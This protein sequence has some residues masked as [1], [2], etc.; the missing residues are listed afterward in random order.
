MA[1]GVPDRIIVTLA[2]RMKGQQHDLVFPKQADKT[3]EIRRRTEHPS[4]TVPSINHPF[5]PVMIMGKAWG[6][7]PRRIS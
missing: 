5:V 1:I 4:I 7:R 6:M 3:P 2:R